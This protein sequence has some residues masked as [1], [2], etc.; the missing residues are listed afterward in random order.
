MSA[1]DGS[2][3]AEAQNSEYSVRISDDGLSVL[4]SMIG[5]RF[6]TIYAP[7]LNVAGADLAAPSLSILVFDRVTGNWRNEY[8]VIRCNWHET[9]LMLNDYWQILVSREDKP[10]Q[11]D[12]NSTGAVVAPCTINYYQATPITKIEVYEFEWVDQGQE[13]IRYDNAI[14]FEQGNGQAFCVA[15]QLNGPGIATD[16]HISEDPVVISQF[17][18][19]S[20]L[21]LCLL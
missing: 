19:G 16:V 10:N 5:N 3:S 2:V 14:R 9:P 12:V 21:R 15:C 1:D 13:S 8:I 11:I 7:C 17:L 20:R 6:H 18:A 4:R